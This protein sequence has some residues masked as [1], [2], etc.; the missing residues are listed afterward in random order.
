MKA[1]RLK[2]A[3]G[4]ALAIG[5]LVVVAFVGVS[6]VWTGAVSGAWRHV[7]AVRTGTQDPVVIDLWYRGTEAVMV[8]RQGERVVAEKRCLGGQSIEQWEHG[9]VVREAADAVRCFEVATDSVLGFVRV[10]QGS[11]FRR[12]GN[13]EIGGV[14][15]EVY[16]SE[17][18]TSEVISIAIDPVRKLPLQAEFQSGETWSWDYPEPDRS[19]PVPPEPAFTAQDAPSEIYRDLEGREAAAALKMAN[20]PEAIAGL[21]LDAVF[22]YTPANGRTASYAVWRS[23][24][25]DREVQLVVSAM[26]GEVVG[27]GIE[28]LGG[29]LTLALQEDGALV[30]ITAPDRETLELA[31]SALRPAVELPA[32]VKR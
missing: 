10:A 14:A 24:D 29:A 12:D 19:V 9:R 1:R 16:R 32:D 6:V 31:V 8:E 4:A 27:L 26:P 11:G 20:V 21:P 7:T 2:G 5:A 22:S 30:R 18:S 17:T 23:E 15:A 13:R 28:D 3:L 25:D